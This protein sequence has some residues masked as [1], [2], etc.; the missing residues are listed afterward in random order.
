MTASSQ[1]HR[2]GRVC[3][4]AGV[5]STSR[6]SACPGRISQRR[7]RQQHVIPQAAAD[8]S[9]S[10][11]SR[12]LKETAAL[13]DLIERLLA[14]RSQQQ[15]AKTVAENIFSFDAKFWMRVATRND[16]AANGAEREA[17][18]NM[19]DTVMVLVREMVKSSEAQLQG[20]SKILQDILSSAADEKGEWF[21]PLTVQQVNQIRA[22]LDR[23]ADSL[24]EALLSNAFAWIRKSGEDRF[25]GMVGLIQKVLQLYAGRALQGKEQK[26]T[27][28][29]LNQVLFAEEAQW[30]PLIRT[31]AA[32]GDISEASLMEAL[33]KRMEGTVLGLQSGSYAQRVQAEYLK[34]VEA[35]AK[36]VFREE[37]GKAASA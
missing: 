9:S 10:D 28:G 37:A 16:T 12:S 32:A 8:G 21:L 17:L 27:E 3:S 26:G 35:R 15:I 31:S 6:A 7:S 29:L 2:S 4:G 1:P 18:G 13:D 33:Q 24:D 25:D 36:T 11:P 5:P 20:S 30:A 14:A 34:E 19:A 22:A 23:H